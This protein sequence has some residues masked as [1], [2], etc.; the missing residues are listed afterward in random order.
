MHFKTCILM[1]PPMFSFDRFQDLLTHLA[2]FLKTKKKENFL[3]MAQ[4]ESYDS[5]GLIFKFDG[6]QDKLAHLIKKFHT[7]CTRHYRR[8]DM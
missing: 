3:N 7:L 1:Q 8:K 2:E 5:N 6:N 4:Q